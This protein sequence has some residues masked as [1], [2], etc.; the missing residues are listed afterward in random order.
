MVDLN[1]FTLMMQAF[2]ATFTLNKDPAAPTLTRDAGSSW[3]YVPG[4]T[5]SH[6]AL[7][8]S[9]FL[10]NYWGDLLS[11]SCS[12]M[13]VELAGCDSVVSLQYFATVSTATQM[14][15]DPNG[16]ADDRPREGAAHVVMLPLVARHGPL[17][18]CCIVT[19]SLCGSCPLSP[20][21]YI[22]A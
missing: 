17:L 6:G 15:L 1:L 9:M 4:A 14:A 5:G 21:H 19:M 2:Q 16:F 20:C 13:E 3:N 10:G 11:T 8:W 22:A 7:A 12:M 18:N